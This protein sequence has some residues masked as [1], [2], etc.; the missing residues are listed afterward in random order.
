MA[1]SHDTP[2]KICCKCKRTLPATDEYFYRSRGRL[3]SPCKQCQRQYHWDNRERILE[4]MAKYRTIPEIRER[5]RI[6]TQN[7]RENPII[8]DRDRNTSREWKRNNPERVLKYMTEYRRENREYLLEY[9]RQSTR[10]YNRNPENRKRAVVR[11]REWRK[12][13]PKKN[14]V[15]HLRRRAREYNALG[16]HTARDIEYLWFEQSGRCGYCGITLFEDY[17][18]DHIIPLSRRGNNNPDNLC[19]T[20]P[21]CNA[22][23]NNKTPS[24]WEKMRGW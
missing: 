9:A 15:L 3:S 20:C 18:V 12:L 2:K 16:N 24:E 19:L 21:D 7:R 17:Q 5:E 13:N 4:R 22:R 1:N 11:V 6:R 14:R 10:N 8:R 23:K